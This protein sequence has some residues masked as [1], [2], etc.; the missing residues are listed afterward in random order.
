MPEMNQNVSSGADQGLEGGGAVKET[1][2]PLRTSATALLSAAD[3]WSTNEVVTARAEAP[4]V[5]G[6]APEKAETAQADEPVEQAA[7]MRRLRPSEVL[8]EARFFSSHG[9]R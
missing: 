1:A 2:A 7:P 9:K 6:K 8:A 4:A 5:I 3:I